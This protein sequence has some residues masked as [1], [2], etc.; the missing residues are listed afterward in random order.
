[1]K[2]TVE[3][4]REVTKDWG[5]SFISKLVLPV[6]DNVLGCGRKTTYYV[7]GSKQLEGTVELNLDEWIVQEK[8]AEINGETMMLKYI[9]G[10]R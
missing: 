9:V 1:M 5:T 10:P 3:F 4:S 7:W 6:V 2:F 8:E